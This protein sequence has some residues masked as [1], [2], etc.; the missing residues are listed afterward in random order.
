LG[1]ERT[2]ALGGPLH[3][4]P[5]ALYAVWTNISHTVFVARWSDGGESFAPGATV[6]DDIFFT[7]VC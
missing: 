1:R 5:T 6:E 2:A 4:I 7:N 3:Y